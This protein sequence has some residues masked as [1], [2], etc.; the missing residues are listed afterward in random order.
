LN[1][2]DFMIARKHVR[3]QKAARVGVLD[4]AVCE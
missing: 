1:T 4:V 3:R 2:D